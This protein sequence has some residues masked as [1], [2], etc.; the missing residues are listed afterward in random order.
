MTNITTT[1]NKI[2]II[3]TSAIGDVIMASPL[4][5]ALKSKYP[6]AE[7]HWLAEPFVHDLI[8]FHP[9]IDKVHSFPKAQLKNLW[10]EKQY[11]SFFKQIRQLKL[12][13]Q[14]E[15]FDLALD[16][17][18]LFKSGI[19]A[20]LAKARVRVGFRSKEGSDFFMTDVIDKPKNE[21]T[22]SS[23]YQ[24]MAEYLQ[25]ET[26]TFLMDISL[27]D[28][29]ITIIN[30][31]ILSKYSNGFAVISPFTTREQKHWTDE[32][33]R[34]FS[35]LFYQRYKLPIIIVGGPNDA[36]HA[37]SICHQMPFLSQV[38]GQ[39]S[40]NESV[41]LIAQAK[42]VVG[43]DTGMTHAG[44]AKETPTLAL[45]G[46]TRPYLI[47]RTNTAEVVYLNKQ[48]APCKRKPSCGGTFDCMN[49]ITPKMV[50]NSVARLF[51]KTGVTN[52]REIESITH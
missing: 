43:V 22:I 17:Q 27:S 36:K 14:S 39:F 37:E 45:F 3:R 6:Q 29:A 46:S 18:G 32:N 30:K 16:V 34:R 2:L 8:R 5:A 25:C 1:F 50:L 15:Q 21:P 35:A 47:T 4:I 13:L 7:I 24:C 9:D 28:Q 44:I 12:Q 23:E 49:D 48:C 10:L 42:L 20:W 33:W 19:W 26:S 38:C 40:L 51:D 52:G 41:A 11:I 31:F